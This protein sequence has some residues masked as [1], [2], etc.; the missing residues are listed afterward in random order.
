MFS[1]VYAIYDERLEQEGAVLRLAVRLVHHSRFLGSPDGCGCVR[2]ELGKK[3]GRACKARATT[4]K[5]LYADMV[6]GGLGR[7]GR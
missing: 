6:V 3:K 1:P 2:G 7:R 4:T 5:S